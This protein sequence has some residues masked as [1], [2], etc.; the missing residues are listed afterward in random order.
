M[1][2]QGVVAKVSDLWSIPPVGPALILES[3][4]FVTPGYFENSNHDSAISTIERERAAKSVR[5]V[6]RATPNSGI[7]MELRPFIVILQENA[8]EC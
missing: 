1:L 6:K 5:K 3:H 4:Q 8:K 2:S 7:V